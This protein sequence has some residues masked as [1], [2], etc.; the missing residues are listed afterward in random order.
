MITQ[1]LRR[2]FPGCVVVGEEADAADPS[3]LGPLAR[4]RPGLRGGPVDGTS[5]YAAGL[6]LFGV[7][8]AAV[9]G[10]EVAG[11]VIHDPVGDDTAFAL[12]GEGAWIAAPDGT[13]RDLRV[14]APVPV[15]A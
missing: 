1:G 11:S 4:R 7:M 8:A 6:P 3:L 13:S 12:R 9:V 5:N 2:M 10:G 14:A 15:T